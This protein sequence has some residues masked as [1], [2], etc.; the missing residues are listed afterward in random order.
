MGFFIYFNF[1]LFSFESNQI[2][3]LN[4]LK[5]KIKETIERSQTEEKD[6]LD[7]KRERE[8]LAEE[9]KT[10]VEE[11]RQINGDINQMDSVI[12]QSEDERIKYLQT[13]RMLN[14]E[15][16]QLKCGIDKMRSHIG[17][18][19]LEEDGPPFDVDLPEAN[20]LVGAFL[21]SD[22]PPHEPL[23]ESA[24]AS[25][26]PLSALLSK[27]SPKAGG[28]GATNK[29]L[30]SSGAAAANNG[31]NPMGFG[32]HHSSGPVGPMH[33]GAS[34][35]SAMAERKMERSVSSAFCQQPPPM[36]T[37]MSCHQQIHRNAPICPYCKAKSRSRHPKKPK[38]KVEN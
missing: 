3:E 26:G 19:R 14:N 8:M 1:S 22:W 17:L 9:K 27:T 23:R 33:G 4:D 24:L 7:F 29:M 15:M 11:L 31:S 32:Q 20:K 21:P 10:L 35:D 2:M 30:S 36:K 18:P 25:A 6:L 12:K 13:A 16:K 38:R 28:I 5:N 37:C 34:S